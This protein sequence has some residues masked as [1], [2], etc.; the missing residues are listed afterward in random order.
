MHL[1]Q[2]CKVTSEPGPH[3][4]TI[5]R[6]QLPPA[7]AVLQ[8]M[9]FTSKSIWMVSLE[10]YNMATL[11]DSHIFRTPE[12]DWNKSKNIY[13]KIRKIQKHTKISLGSSSHRQQFVMSIST[14]KQSLGPPGLMISFQVDWASLNSPNTLVTLVNFFSLKN[15]NNSKVTECKFQTLCQQGRRLFI[16]YASKAMKSWESPET[17]AELLE[18]CC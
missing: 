3:L 17:T 1:A 16:C 14:C 13:R 4:Q 5:S 9:A 11:T 6:V 12:Q 8:G 15:G 18:N 10:L 7:G 2:S